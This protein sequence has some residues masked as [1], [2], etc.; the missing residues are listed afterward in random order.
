MTILSRL[1]TQSAC[2]LLLSVLSLTGFAQRTLQQRTDS[3]AALTKKYVNEKDAEKLYDL[4]AQDFKNAIKKEEFINVTQK[5]LFPLGEL[6]EII[7]ERN[8]D[9]VILYKGIFATKPMTLAIG[10]GDG[11]KVSTFFFRQY[12]APRAGVEKIPHNNPLKTEQDKIVDSIVRTY[13]QQAG[14]EGAS[15]GILK[16]GTTWFYGYGEADKTK[17]NIPAS[18]TLFELG[19]I[20]KTITATIVALAIGEG[21]VKLDDPVNKYLP[22]SIPSLEFNGCVVTIKDL[23][24]HTSALPRMPADFKDER[25]DENGTIIYP[26]EKFFGWLKHLKLTREPGLKSEYS[27]AGFALAST[28]MQRTYNMSYEEMVQKFIAHPMGMKNIRIDIRQQ[29][30]A[31]YAKG[32]DEDG[33]YHFPRNLPP[34]YQG[35]GGL[36]SNAADM[37]KYAKAQWDAPNKK[38]E[39]AIQLTHDTTFSDKNFH[40]GMAWVLLKYGKLNAL[41]HNGASG[42]FR[43]YLGV[44]PE[45]KVA[46]VILVNSTVGADKQGA[47]LL[48]RLT[49][50][51][52]TKP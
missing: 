9:G 47:M 27:N 40:I 41:F 17:H 46:V 24:N 4:T 20:S 7:F 36:R 52:L 29:D 5:S 33:S 43:S 22:D 1:L 44:A 25:I 42:G 8:A 23:L 16:N 15:I 26:I 51:D 12:I 48:Q 31:A 32:Y 11:D 35:A 13:L 38:L 28:I 10:L 18:N 2:I 6:K 21:K 49:T 37:L 50:A 30:S 3:V 19:S 14:T 34:I 45:K 39:K